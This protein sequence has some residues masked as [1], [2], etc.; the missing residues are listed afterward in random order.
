MVMLCFYS[1][2]V[3]RNSTVP[4]FPQGSYQNLYLVIQMF[5]L[6]WVL[7]QIITTKIL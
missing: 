2:H 4:C 5:N 1:P 3:L 6:I 7:L